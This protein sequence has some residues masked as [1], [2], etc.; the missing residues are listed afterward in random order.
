MINILFYLLAASGFGEAALEYDAE[1]YTK[2]QEKYSSLTAL[3]QSEWDSAVASY[4]LGL[5]LLAEQKWD[6]A[7]DTF[8][9]LLEQTPELPDLLQRNVTVALVATLGSEAY[10]ISQQVGQHLGD[11]SDNLEKAS[12]LLRHARRLIT[13]AAALDCKVQAQKG[14]SKCLPNKHLNA[15]ASWINQL[16]VETTAKQSENFIEPSSIY[17]ALWRLQALWL[18][19]GDKL[20][21]LEKVPSAQVP[22]Y[23]QVYYQEIFKF[24]PLLTST[25][26]LVVVPGV[27]DPDNQQKAE[28]AAQE[29][30][31]SFKDLL[32]KLNSQTPPHEIQ[33]SVQQGQQALESLVE[34]VYGNDQGFR[35]LNVLI[36]WYERALRSDQLQAFVVEALIK[37]QK[38]IETTL[39]H[40]NLNQA[41]QLATK[42]QQVIREGDPL[43]AQLLLEKA[44]Q[45][46]RDLILQSTVVQPKTPLEVL[47][48]AIESQRQAVIMMR[49]WA[50]R[51]NTLPDVVR[52]VFLDD[53]KQVLSVAQPFVESVLKKQTAGFTSN[54]CQKRPWNEV[55]PLFYE[56]AH[57][58]ETAIQT[59]SH[60]KGAVQD[61]LKLEKQALSK[62]M[63]AYKVLQEP[64][65]AGNDTCFA[66]PPP[67]KKDQPKEEQKPQPTP[68]EL[69]E[70]LR[71]VQ[72]MEIDDRLE[73]VP[74]VFKKGDKPW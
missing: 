46:L 56:G 16:L 18:A 26:K 47:S 64:I 23:E 69:E 65:K 37:E 67:P 43:Q 14:R 66:P 39:K 50:S 12:A 38:E 3:K 28:A 20:D 29:I 36:S 60:E 33:Q 1:E 2:A 7:A 40:E 49:L 32:S 24:T 57:N 73:K 62:Y 41:N 13:H 59:L 6:E 4:N 22:Q 35:R 25:S 45:K 17:E 55:L 54:Q 58:A 5:S 34:S 31:G 71:H 15:I 48:K 51:R 68:K 21:V 72:E 42:A 11:A 30:Q 9:S 19:I 52:D 63:Q 10:E 27:I 8:N 74:S 61:I 70:I 44:R 53:Q